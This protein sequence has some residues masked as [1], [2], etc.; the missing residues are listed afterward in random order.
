MDYQFEVTTPDAIPTLSIRTRASVEKLPQ[1]MGR[2]FG[3]IYQYLMEIGERP[4]NAAYSGYY[5]MDMSDLDV[6]IGW[7][8]EK[9]LPGRGDIMAT[10]IPGGKQVSCMYKGPYNKMEPTYQAMTAWMAANNYTPTGVAYEFYYNDPS[11]VPVS[12]LLTKIVFPVRE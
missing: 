2:I 3:Q 7:V 12:E 4:G 9:P 6:E 5:N 11:M 8:L 1:E 10:E